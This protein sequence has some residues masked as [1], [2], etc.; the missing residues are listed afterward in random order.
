MLAAS[1]LV[2]AEKCFCIAQ[3]HQCDNIS[4][5]STNFP[6]ITS[7]YILCVVYSSAK[8]CRIKQFRYVVKIISGKEVILKLELEDIEGK[9]WWKLWRK[10]ICLKRGIFVSYAWSNRAINAT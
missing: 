5:S 7:A 8:S 3:F 2:M 9:E 4:S 10:D 6:V 1:D